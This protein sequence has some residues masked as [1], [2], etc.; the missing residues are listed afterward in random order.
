[1]FEDMQDKINSLMVSAHEATGLFAIRSNSVP[2][3]SP[4]P[5]TPIAPMTALT[6]FTRGAG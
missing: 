3:P 4:T 1:L 6:A 5:I 2:L